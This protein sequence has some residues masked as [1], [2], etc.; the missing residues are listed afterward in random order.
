MKTIKINL[1]LFVF[2]KIQRSWKFFHTS[3]EQ[4]SFVMNAIDY[5][6]FI[7]FVLLFHN[8]FHKKKGLCHHG[9]FTKI[10]FIKKR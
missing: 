9:R 6:N 8:F 4:A 1:D 2:K 3:F 5:Y 10:Y 7:V